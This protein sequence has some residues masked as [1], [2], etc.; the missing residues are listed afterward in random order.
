M[1]HPNVVQLLDMMKT[2]TNC[3][4]V[5]EYCKGGDLSKYLKSK[6][7][8]EEEEVQKYMR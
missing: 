4:L 6:S 8:L 5:F 3:Y 1:K 7:R 2:P